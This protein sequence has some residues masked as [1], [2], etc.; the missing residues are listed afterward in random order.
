MSN[1]DQEFMKL[2]IKED[3]EFKKNHE[4]TKKLED[5]ETSRYPETRLSEQNK[6]KRAENRNLSLSG[7][8]D[9]KKILLISMHYY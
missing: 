3:P 6:T 4:D 8:E 7:D 5:Q 2:M 1:E 9:I